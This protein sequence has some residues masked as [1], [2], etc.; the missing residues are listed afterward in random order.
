MQSRKG[1]S[2]ENSTLAFHLSVFAPLLF[3]FGFE[4]ACASNRRVTCRCAHGTTEVSLH[5]RDR[6]GNGVYRSVGLQPGKW[7]TDRR[8]RLSVALGH[9]SFV[10]GNTDATARET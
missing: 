8:Q 5:G 6:S 7:R 4:I 9:P 2:R 10:G 1:Q 3:T